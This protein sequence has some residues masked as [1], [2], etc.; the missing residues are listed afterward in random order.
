MKYPG[1][2]PNIGNDELSE[3]YETVLNAM[4]VAPLAR[5]IAPKLGLDPTDFD[6]IAEIEAMLDPWSNLL[7]GFDPSDLRDAFEGDYTGDDPILLA[8]QS[9]VGGKWDGITAVADFIQSLVNAILQALRGVPVVGGSLA[10]I[11]SDV[12]SLNTTAV[13]AHE[14]AQNVGTQVNYVQQ[15]I[16]IKAGVPIYDAGP[17]PTGVVSIPWWALMLHS[18]TL[19]TISISGTITGGSHAHDVGGTTGSS[20][21]TSPAH[22]H[23]AGSLSATSASSTHSHTNSLTGSGSVDNMTVPLVYATPTY[24]PWASVRFPSPAERTLLT[25]LAL[26]S[27]TLTTVNVD[28]YKMQPDGSSTFVWSSPNIAS[29]IGAGLSW[30]QV[31][32]PDPI[33]PDIGDVYEVQWRTTGGGSVGIAGPN[34]PYATPISGFRPYAPGSGRDP[35]VTPVPSTIATATRDAMYVGTVPF[36]S[37]GIDVGQTELPRYFYD[38]FN[39]ATLGIRWATRGEDVA[40]DDGR[41]VKDGSGNDGIAM[42]GQQLLTDK[43]S[44]EADLDVSAFGYAGLGL[45]C[46]YVMTGAWLA[47][48]SGGSYIQTGTFSSRT[49]RKTMSGG[50]G[51][52]QLTYD[53]ADNTYRA[54][55]DGVFLDSWVDSTNIVPHGNGN[56]W[57]GL[58]V[59][60]TFGNTGAAD[61]F[62][63][64]DVE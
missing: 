17:D 19:S 50:D 21:S 52:Y 56:R 22:T 9:F 64:A 26:G 37:I 6:T 61:N 20:S 36:V 51:R 59:G 24:A 58:L 10:E 8:I 49:T 43:N 45:S 1:R 16:A 48:D 62:V 44:I 39:R 32:M 2:N 34:L 41:L 46:T 30:V 28:V 31:V 15:V 7:G 35:S 54:Y 14:S 47:A 40:L 25:F 57:T 29:S 27:G 4:V 38:D 63:A 3:V 55:K 12:G 60:G 53:P 13:T 11:V 33:L 18:H 42:Y 5:L 23:A